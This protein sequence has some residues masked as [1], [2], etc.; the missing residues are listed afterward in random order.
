MEMHDA[1]PHVIKIHNTGSMNTSSNGLQADT[2]LARVLK[3][4]QHLEDSAGARSAA[5]YLLAQSNKFKDSVRSYLQFKSGQAFMNAGLDSLAVE[6]LEK[7]LQVGTR[8]VDAELC[9]NLLKATRNGSPMTQI[10]AIRN[11][12]K[13]HP[14]YVPAHF[15]LGLLLQRRGDF[16]KAAS[17]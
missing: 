8:S 11:F 16:Q 12:I 4:T 6:A 3:H 5:D 15:R 9:L 17:A 1:N 2:M 13:K 14:G 7:S 10:V